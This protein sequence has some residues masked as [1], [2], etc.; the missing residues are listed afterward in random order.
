MSAPRVS[1]VLPVLNGERYLRASVDS[2]LAQTFRDFELLIID[3]GSTDSSRAIAESY[4]D[5]RVRILINEQNLGLPKSFNVGLR[6]ARGSLIARHDADDI[7]LPTRFE[8]Q[9]AW[10]D[11]HP[12]VVLLGTQAR[13]IDANGR[14]VA[15]VGNSK[16]LGTMGIRWG[17]L[18]FNPFIHTT[19]MYRREEI[20]ALG[21]YNETYDASEDLD[22]WSRV[23]AKYECANLPDTLVQYRAHGESVA[24]RRDPAVIESRLVNVQRNLRIQRANV[25]RE[26]ASEALATEWPDLW[27]AMNVSWLFGQPERPRRALELIPELWKGFANVHRGVQPDADVRSVLAA[28]YIVAALYLAQHDRVASLRAFVAALHVDAL[29]ARRSI[30]RWLLLVMTTPALITFLKSILSRALRKEAGS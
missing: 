27:T 25:V 19:V 12:E 18:F 1:V 16:P 14:P 29:I 21:M 4:D 6:A 24:G 30:A 26:T 13:T 22:L 2:V 3:D 7:A 11:A 5:P 8:K 17:L 28:A 23:I 10:L 20:V 15:D 9:V